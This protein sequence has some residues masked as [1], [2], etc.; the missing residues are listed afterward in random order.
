MSLERLLEKIELDAREEGRGIVDT[1]KAEVERIM[2]EGREEARR[3]AEA[4][5]ASFR[6]RGRRE[7]TKI[8]SEALA[9][10][11]A[12]F[13]S[14]QDKLFEEAFTEAMRL[15]EDL[16]EERY[17]AWLKRTIVNNVSGKPEEIVAAPYDRRLL[18]D[19][20]LEEINEA[21]KERGGETALS[22]S[23]EEAGFSRGVMLR[24]GN[25]VN[26]LSLETL[27]REV[28]DRH[29][30]QVLKMLFGEVDVRGASR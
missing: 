9:E 8:M 28:R 19:G 7:R 21:I 15:F 24:S 2:E 13:L 3:A 6:E 14:A 22:L 10:S 5:R 30:E 20:L 17:R 11:R 27:M 25:F 18:A 29:E 16:P 1:A 4:I 26:N 23:A 12:A